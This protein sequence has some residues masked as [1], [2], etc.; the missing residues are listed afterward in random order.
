ML[1]LSFLYLLLITIAN[2]PRENEACQHCHMT[3]KVTANM[4]KLIEVVTLMLNICDNN[5]CVMSP[6]FSKFQIYI[7]IERE[8]LYKGGP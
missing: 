6:Y 1:R 7:S 2:F 8:I 3:K 5:F 4:L